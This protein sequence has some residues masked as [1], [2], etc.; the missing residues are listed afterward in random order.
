MAWS[1]ILL[2]SVLLFPSLLPKM[3][4]REE[5]VHCEEVTQ[6]SPKHSAPTFLLLLLHP[7]Y[8]LLCPVRYLLNPT[9]SS[10]LGKYLA[11]SGSYFPCCWGKKMG[12]VSI[13]HTSTQPETSQKAEQLEQGVPAGILLD[14]G[15]GA[16]QSSLKE[17]TLKPPLMLMYLSLSKLCRLGNSTW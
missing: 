10:D 4:A 11:L 12:F 2:A 15:S 14:V 5:M 13:S 9:S 7:T 8:S 3:R 17:V 1:A 16:H 6:A